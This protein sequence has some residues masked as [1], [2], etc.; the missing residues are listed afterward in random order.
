[1]LEVVGWRW[2]VA[3]VLCA[4]VGTGCGESSSPSSSS[5]RA[6]RTVEAKSHLVAV[7]YRAFGS[8]QQDCQDKFNAG[9]LK[10]DAEGAS[11][12][13]DGLTASQLETAIET[14]RKQIV[15]VGQGGAQG[16]KAAS[17]Q[18]ADVVQQEEGS[19]HALHAD[20]ARLDARS[21]NRDFE[22]ADADAGRE[23]K[24]VGPLVHSCA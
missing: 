15:A 21:F 1:M 9:V 12:I 24:L 3:G 13:D 20:L 16:C 14:L 18:L 22:A 8:A 7:A 17:Q 4:V 19:I 5:V 11:C 6:I 2:W 23:A 10:T